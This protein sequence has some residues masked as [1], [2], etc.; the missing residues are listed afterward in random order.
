MKLKNS[1]AK[2]E[3]NVNNFYD[4]KQSSVL[5]YVKTQRFYTLTDRYT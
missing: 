3:Y 2:V 4:F 1:F 5:I